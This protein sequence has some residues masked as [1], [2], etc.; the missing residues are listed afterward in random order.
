MLV[1][2]RFDEADLEAEQRVIIEEMKM[3]DDSP[4]EYLGEIFSEGFFPNHPLGLSIAGTPETVK[5]FD[6]QATRKYHG[7][8]FRLKT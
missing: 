7:E 3:I 5:S 1:H 8:V 4:E 2:P 6:Q